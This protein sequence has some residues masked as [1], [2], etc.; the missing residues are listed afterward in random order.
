MG[1]NRF[2]QTVHLSTEDFTAFVDFQIAFKFSL[3]FRPNLARL[4]KWIGDTI[5]WCIIRI[6]CI[7]FSV[8]SFSLVHTHT[9]THTHLI[10]TYSSFSPH[11]PSLS[12]LSQHSFTLHFSFPCSL[13]W[14]CP[15][16]IVFSL[17]V[18]SYCVSFMVFSSTVLS[19]MVFS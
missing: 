17:A 11:S 8:Y 10:H 19:V 2:V 13:S 5:R 14:R 18:F 7:S 15:T 6:L 1:L 9:H 3:V 4:G 12:S 16:Y